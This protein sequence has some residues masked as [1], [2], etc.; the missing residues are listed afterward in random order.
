M[1]DE[2]GHT[3]ELERR[4]NQTKTTWRTETGG[5]IQE[6]D[7]KFLGKFVREKT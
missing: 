2:S 3:C 7:I 6:L 1:G 5:H 4:G